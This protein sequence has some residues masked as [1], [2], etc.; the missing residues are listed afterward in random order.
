MSR[1]LAAAA[2][3]VLAALGGTVALTSGES[4]SGQPATEP[5]P[6]SGGPPG[7]R[8]A[9]PNSKDRDHDGLPDSWERRYGISTARSRARGTPTTTG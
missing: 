5:E 2:V 1:W 7:D 6:Q 9:K 4:N 8:A 3:I